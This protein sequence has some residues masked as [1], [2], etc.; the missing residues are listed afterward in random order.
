MKIKIT[1]K[2]K[3]ANLPAP[4]IDNHPLT[5]VINYKYL[6]VILDHQLNLKDHISKTMNIVTHK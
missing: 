3:Q 4:S 6:G 5:E 1:K 2:Q